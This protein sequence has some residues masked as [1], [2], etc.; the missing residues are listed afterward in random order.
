MTELLLCHRCRQAIADGRATLRVIDRQSAVRAED[1]TL[2]VSCYES[3][4]RWSTRKHR[5]GHDHD[6][7]PGAFASARK[8][9]R[10]ERKIREFSSHSEAVDYHVKQQRTRLLIM[11]VGL[12]LGL[13]ALIGVLVSMLR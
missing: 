4:V 13:F 7:A 8:E 2:C 6:D 3:F 1:M 5:H 9:S 12:M 10:R 11:S